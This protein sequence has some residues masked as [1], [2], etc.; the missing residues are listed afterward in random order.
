M[1][2]AI[3]EVLFTAG[4]FVNAALFIPQ[5]VKLYTSKNPESLSLITFLG[6]NIIQGLTIAHGMIRDDNLLIL[7]NI[8]NM[9]TSGAITLLLIYYLMNKKP[10]K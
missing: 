9:I 5:A 1:L 3:I 2:H 6:F 4:L 7:G 8:L 10:S